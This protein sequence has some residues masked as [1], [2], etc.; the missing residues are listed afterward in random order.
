M[1]FVFY[2]INYFLQFYHRGAIVFGKLLVQSP[3]SIVSTQSDPASFKYSFIKVF[4]VQ[5]IYY[6]IELFN[7]LLL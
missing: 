1:I 7:C 3:L 5:R 2:Y 4:I 6:Y